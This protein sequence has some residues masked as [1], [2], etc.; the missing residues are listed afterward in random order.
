LHEAVP[1]L[2]PP[3]LL[4]LLGTPLAAT[5]CLPVAR[6][7]L[8]LLRDLEQMAGLCRLLLDGPRLPRCPRHGRE[9]FAAAAQGPAGAEHF[10]Q[11]QSFVLLQVCE[12]LPPLP[13]GRSCGGGTVRLVAGAA[14]SAAVGHLVLHL[15]GNQL[16]RRCLS[17]P[18]PSGAQ[19]RELHAVY[20]VLSAPGSR[21][22]RPR[23]R[24]P[25]AG[26]PAEALELGSPL[27]RRPV[28]PAWRR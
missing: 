18:P 21:A 5:P 8:L 11:S 7:E 20:S 28:R 15:R 2:L 3:R 27:Y 23:P 24:L 4:R 17:G 10:R 19:P 12:F 22:N 13:G 6:G 14:G 9:Q 16:S 1:A 26:P 25:A